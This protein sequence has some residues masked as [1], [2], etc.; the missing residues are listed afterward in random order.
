MKKSTIICVDDERI[1]LTSLRA[2]LRR[3]FGNEFNVEIAESGEEA[4]EIFL[5]LLEDNISVPLIITDQIMPN[6][7]GDELLQFI[8]KTSKEVRTI[9]LTGQADVAAVGNAVNTANL[10]RFIS[11]PWDETDLNMTVKEA[12]KSY[13][14]EKK[15]NTQNEILEELVEKLTLQNTNLEALVNERTSEIQEQKNIIEKTNKDITDSIKYA[16][17]IQNAIFA[18]E[19]YIHDI[20]PNHFVLFKPKEIVSGDFFWIRQINKY[21][22]VVAAD[23]TGHGV[24][25]AFMSMLGTSFL[26]ELVTS[27]T[28]NNPGEIL[29]NLREKVKKSLHQKGKIGEQRDGMD[30]AFYVID[31]ETLELQYSGAYNSLL[32]IREN[33]NI[34]ENK[35]IITLKGDRQPIAIHKIEKPFTNQKFQLQKGDSIYS[36]SDGYVDQFG[37][38]Y[39]K[40]MKMNRFKEILLSVSGK[41]MKEQKQ[42]LENYFKKW[43]GKYRQI[44]DVLVIGVKISIDV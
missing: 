25:G 8:Y 1:V 32:I 30:M 16:Q 26:N 28:L 12:I 42:L 18:P 29:N 38:E 39:G 14:Q 5:E 43:S 31:S 17:K 27:E 11:K 21:V 7:K 35:E 44:D 34:D 41:P 36:F 20:I 15:I 6:I 23:C 3:E 9:M 2:Q 40:K 19:K 37:G 22:V 33:R 10:F 13:F 24:P 4:K